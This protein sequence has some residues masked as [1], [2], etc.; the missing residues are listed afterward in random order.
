MDDWVQGVGSLLG[1]R[2]SKA[3]V[4]VY[5]LDYRNFPQVR[6]CAASS[7]SH[8]LLF[9]GKLEMSSWPQLLSM[10]LCIYTSPD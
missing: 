9:C 1:R 6:T 3:K 2:L 7:A 8:L 10:T 5:C 4:L